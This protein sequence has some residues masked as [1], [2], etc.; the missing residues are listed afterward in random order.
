MR[1]PSTRA[2]LFDY[3]RT[4]VTFTYPTDDL[5]RVIGE[6]RPRIEAALGVPAPEA[7]TI[8]DGVLM[9]LEDYVGS[10]S[11]DEI[12]YIDVYRETW[13]RAGMRLPD[14]L[15]NEILDAEQQCWDRAVTVDP[16]A[17]ATLEWL[18]D[19]G[20]LRAL[21]S[22][23]PFPADMMRRQ[24]AS[25]GL[26]ELVDAAIFSSDVGKRK[27]APEMYRAALDAVETNAEDAFFVGDRVRE[28]YEGPR[29]LGM[30]AVVV[31]RH[32]EAEPR[33]GVPTIASLAELPA[34][35]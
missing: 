35:L 31:T 5:L 17:L 1:M 24:V 19:R 16:D 21:C 4:I 18:R 30:R 9:P 32:A 15:L 6:F 22:N 27:P 8:L 23:A 13:A 14:A 2:V 26:A 12:D 29:A 34:L 10:M 7:Q 33:D 25:N 20:V 11:E 28:D 3:G